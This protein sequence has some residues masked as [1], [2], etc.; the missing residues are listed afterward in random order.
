[1]AW[2]YPM[3]TAVQKAHWSAT[4]RE[5]LHFAIAKRG[6][7]KS[8]MQR[9]QRCGQQKKCGCRAESMTQMAL[10]KWCAWGAGL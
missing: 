8:P 2:A 5:G 10:A 6:V 1:M 9:R 7:L 3:R 4:L